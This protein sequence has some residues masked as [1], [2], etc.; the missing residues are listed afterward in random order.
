MSEIRRGRELAGDADCLDP[1]Y[2]PS[3]GNSQDGRC[4]AGNHCAC[5]GQR[6][7]STSGYCFGDAGTCVVEQQSFVQD[8]AG[9]MIVPVSTGYSCCDSTMRGSVQGAEQTAASLE[10][11]LLKCDAAKWC[12]A[13]EWRPETLA[14]FLIL[15]PDSYVEA[16]NLMGAPEN[17]GRQF[18]MR[19]VWNALTVGGE[20]AAPEAQGGEESEHE[21][22][23][24][25][26]CGVNMTLAGEESSQAGGIDV[27]GGSED[28]CDGGMWICYKDNLMSCLPKEVASSFSA[29]HDW[30][31][32]EVQEKSTTTPVVVL[33]QA[34]ES[35]GFFSSSAWW[36]TLVA[37]SACCIAGL[38]LFFWMRGRKGSRRAR[39]FVSPLS[40]RK[41]STSTKSFLSRAQS[42]R[43]RSNIQHASSETSSNRRTSADAR[44]PANNNFQRAQSFH[45][46][47]GFQRPGVL[48]GGWGNEHAEVIWTVPNAYPGPRGAADTNGTQPTS[49][50]A[51][52]SWFSFNS[53]DP[54]VEASEEQPPIRRA[55]SSPGGRR[56]ADEDG[57]ESPK[58]SKVLSEKWRSLFRSDPGVES[59]EDAP[60]LRRARSSPGDRGPER[61]RANARMKASRG[62][63]AENSK[64]PPGATKS[65]SAK[66]S[67][68]FRSPSDPDLESSEEQPPTQRSMSSPAGGR[69]PSRAR[70]DARTEGPGAAAAESRPKSA[71]T[72]SAQS[73]RSPSE[74]DVESFEEHPPRSC[75]SSPVSPGPTRA[76][77]ELPTMDDL[78]LEINSPASDAILEQ[79][80]DKVLRHLRSSTPRSQRNRVFLELCRAWHPDKNGGDERLATLAFQRLQAS[81]TW[82]M[83]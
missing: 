76:R 41:R 47:C 44:S 43:S 26:I 17:P 45:S 57:T 55:R 20:T 34:E 35:S 70:T 68:F 48:R 80:V 51:R 27:Y 28:S 65:P 30:N 39:T 72:T 81:R 75:P 71:E 4:P 79:K 23:N 32:T 33:Q 6:R 73:N 83:S 61:E 31:C 53:S 14:C 7:C 59:S 49:P 11:C 18:C 12:V 25:S 52:W 16:L 1:C 37:L 69:R 54:G 36:I 15:R 13:A 77:A 5:H 38:A 42:G 64:E 24:V 19:R 40:S 67:W 22:S 46:G 3:S 58:I 63:A 82:F 29:A 78:R 62:S 8:S 60:P 56:S 21:V 2:Q 9:E 50:S 10:R 66:R 74:P